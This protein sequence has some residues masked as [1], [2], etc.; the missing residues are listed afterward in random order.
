[1]QAVKR[2]LVAVIKQADDDYC[3]LA[4]RGLV[5]HGR[6]TTLASCRQRYEG[7]CLIKFFSPGG[8]MDHLILVGGLALNGEAIRK[9]LGL[10]ERT[11]R[12]GGA[13]AA[14]LRSAHPAG[15]G[16][17]PRYNPPNSRRGCI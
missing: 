11:P 13:E 8:A 7:E 4:H 16:K 15:I 6:V 10:T 3:A 14:S 2:L 12:P 9:R 17:L 5:V 1:M